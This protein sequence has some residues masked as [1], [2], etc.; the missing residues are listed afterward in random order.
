MLETVVIGAGIAGCAA[1]LALWERGAAVTIVERSRP[2]A[3]ATGASAGILAVQCE[4]FGPTERFR[5]CLE[6]RARF[7][8]FASKVEELSGH[9]LHVRWDGMLIAN[10]SRREHHRA[11]E[12]ARWQREAGDT[13]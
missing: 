13:T 8:E 6:S 11:T 4:Q 12:A 9:A 5:L 2:G 7:P 3:G 1:A 10:F